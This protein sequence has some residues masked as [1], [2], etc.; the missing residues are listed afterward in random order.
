MNNRISP[1]SGSHIMPFLTATDYLVSGE[2]FELYHDPDWDMLLT[3]PQPENLNPY[4]ESENYQPH[5]HHSHNWLNVLYNLVRNRS[6]RY[7]LSLIKK[8]H[9]KARNILDYG[10]ATGEFLHYLSQKKIEV[11]GVEPNNKARKSA[12]KL[13]NNKV[14]ASIEE[15]NRNFDV[16]SL[17]HVLEHLPQPDKVIEKLKTKLT[18]EGILIIAVPNFKSHDAQH[19]GS[20]WAAYDVPR[21][22]WHFSPHAVNML[23]DKYHMQVIA[24]EP[25]F[26]DSFYVSLLSEQ[27]RHGN[28]RFLTALFNGLI[29]NIKA[30]KTGQ[31][32]SLIYIVKKQT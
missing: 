31:Y 22:L 30:V 32:S 9:P 25:L 8:Y 18:P 10:T 19:Y 26:F 6:Y 23:F 15:I 16:I 29:S 28:K 5:Q 17:W 27:N 2:K 11:W 12:N 3:V 24:Q 21:H 13:L 4:Y 7:K 20:Y 14:K 1:L